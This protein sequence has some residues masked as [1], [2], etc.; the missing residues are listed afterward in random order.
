MPSVK[1]NDGVEIF[2]KDWASG[3]PIVISR[4][5]PRSADD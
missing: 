2:Y 4:S 3:Q 1:T 5:W